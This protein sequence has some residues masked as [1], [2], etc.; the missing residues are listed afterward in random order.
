MNYHYKKL[1]GEKVYL[2]PA[3]MD[4]VDTFVVWMNDFQITDYTGRSSQICSYEQEKTFVAEQVKQQDS[5]FMAIVRE[6]NEEVIGTISLNRINFV[7]RAATLGIMIGNDENRSKGYGTE[8]IGLILDFAFNYLN[9]NSV[10]L[11]YLECNVRARKCYEK[12]GFKEI[13][14]RRKCKFVNGKYY[15]SVMMDILAEEF[16]VEYIKNK[17]VK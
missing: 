1:Q 9:L 6:D 10:F 5:Y 3:S 4:D 11:T 17:N 14:R 2:S 8:A 7:D 15:D 12:V 13:G 16:T